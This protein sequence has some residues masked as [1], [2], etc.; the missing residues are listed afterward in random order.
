MNVKQEA[1][2]DP[3]SSMPSQTDHPKTKRFPVVAVVVVVLLVIGGVALWEQVLEDRLI[4]KRWGVVEQGLI[5]RSGQLSRHLIKRQL[6]QS[7]VQVVVDLTAE[8]ADDPDQ[9]AELQ[10]VSELGIERHRYPL[11]GDGTGDIRMYAEAINQIHR[12][13]QKHRPV[14]VHC[15][16]GAQRTGGVIACYR[17]LVQGRPASEAYHEM[18]RYGWDPHDDRE[19]LNYVNENLPRLAGMLVQG[20][21]IDQV[22]DPLPQ[23]GP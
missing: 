23:L 7:Q 5:Y 12:A 18:Q 2:K 21:V 3:L 20:G 13:A 11:R 22:P 8:V 6:D 14:L 15:A 17:M 4:P 10:A 16:A 9:I 19:M 1:I